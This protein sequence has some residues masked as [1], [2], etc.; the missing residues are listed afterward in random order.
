MWHP[1]T[2]T[3]IRQ[4]I[5]GWLGGAEPFA[6]GQGYR[7]GPGIRRMLSGTPPILSLLALGPAV[8]TVAEAGIERIRAKSIA[9]TEHAIALADEIVPRAIL[10][11]PRDARRRGGHVTLDHP[12]LR[13]D[14]AAAVGEGRDP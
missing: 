3:T 7:P 9:L 12:G 8:D 2:S 4:P 11:T 13:G 5:Q 1:G 6:M 10:A 14:H